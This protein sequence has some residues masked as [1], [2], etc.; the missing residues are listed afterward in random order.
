MDIQNIAAGAGIVVS[1]IIG[2]AFVMKLVIDNA[3][4]SLN[5]QITRDFVTKEEFNNHITHCEKN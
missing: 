5:L 3:V 2:N 4:K 1:I